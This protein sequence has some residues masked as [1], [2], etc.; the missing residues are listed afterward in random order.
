MAKINHRQQLGKW[1]E[2]L[3]REYLLTKGYS[4]VAMNVRTSYGEIDLIVQKDQLIVFVEVKTRTSL[5]CGLPEESITKKKQEH[6]HNA[7][8]SYMLEHDYPDFDWRIDVIS[9]MST[10]S[11][12]S[13]L[14]IIHFE[15]AI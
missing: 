12:Q 14:E 2:E 15:N 8:Q 5:T 6:L 1:G 10:K 4:L 9:I 7:I 13:K 3:A 11:P